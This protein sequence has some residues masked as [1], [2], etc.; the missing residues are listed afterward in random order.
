TV[1]RKH[2]GLTP[3]HYRERHENL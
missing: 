3:A 2:T 1:F